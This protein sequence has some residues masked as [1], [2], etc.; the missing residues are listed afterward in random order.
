MDDISVRN[1]ISYLVFDIESVPDP[2]LVSLVRTHG[3]QDPEVALQEYRD[4]LIAKNGVDFVPYTYQV[5]I[6]LALAKLRED[7][8]LDDLIVLKVE[9]LGPDGICRR[10]WQGWDYYNHPMLVSFNGRRFDMPLLE[11]TAF[12][13][14]LSLRSWMTDYSG[15]KAN[16]NRFNNTHLDLYD[17]M[18]NYGACTFCGGLDLAAKAL[19]KSGKI[20]VKGE[21]VQEMF[22]QNRLSEIHSYC[23]CDVL[24]TY[25]VF[26]RYQLM[27]GVI[28]TEEEQNLIEKTRAFL[29]ARADTEPVYR[30]YLDAWRDNDEFL[31]KNNIFAAFEKNAAA[32]SRKN[33]K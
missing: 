14:G 9:E 4:E 17:F 11:H 31:R 3:K 24:D 30:E 18:T 6:S 13:Y 23:R 25:F 10:F 1:P 22:D 2:A 8:T 21:M 19:H 5:P 33:Q 32:Q 12:R 16:R 29:E 27:R 20:D 28:S 15:G 26:L 7:L